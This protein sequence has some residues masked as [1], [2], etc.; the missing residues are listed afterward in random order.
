[1][2]ADMADYQLR[3]R[4]EHDNL[5]HHLHIDYHYYQNP[6]RL[7]AETDVF[8][9]HQ[10]IREKF[11]SMSIYIIDEFIFH[12]EFLLNIC[13]M[14]KFFLSTSPSLYSSNQ[15]SMIKFI[16]FYEDLVIDECI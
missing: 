11:I 10:L 1:M 8:R 14:E 16:S 12:S 3:Q 15:K 9:Y 4:I 13:I 7:D 6:S 5:K 2:I